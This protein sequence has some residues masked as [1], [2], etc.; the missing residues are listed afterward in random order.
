[1][2]FVVMSAAWLLYTGA[3]FTTA[4]DASASAVP[5]VMAAFVLA[6]AAGVAVPLAPAGVGVREAVL[7]YLLTPTLGFEVA[8][9]VSLFSR[10]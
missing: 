7:I 5:T 2:V 6:F 3:L 4:P 10:E 1:M 9:A 8:A